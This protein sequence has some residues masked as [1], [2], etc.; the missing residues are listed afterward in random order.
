[1]QPSFWKKRLKRKKSVDNNEKYMKQGIDSKALVTTL[2]MKLP[3]LLVIAVTGAIVGSGLNLILALYEKS[4]AKYVS[5]T[6]YYIEFSP[7]VL[8]AADYYNDYTWNDVIGTDL[9]LGRIMEIIGNGYDRS[10]VKGMIEADIVSDVR[11]LKITIKGDNTDAVS[12]VQSAFEKALAEFGDTMNEFTSIYIID[13]SGIS[14]EQVSYFTFRAALLG[15][16]IFLF[17]SLFVIIFVFCLGSSFYTKRDISKTLDI[18]VLGTSFKDGEYKGVIHMPTLKYND[19]FYCDENDKNKLIVII[20]FGKSYR[21]KIT[22]E[23]YDMELKGMKVTG[24]I[25]TD[26]DNSWYRIYRG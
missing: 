18:P 21:E 17:I 3:I 22:D 9:I 12:T 25:M 23:I 19:M 16:F 6:K 24:A 2:I 26:V 1:L 13:D 15:A 8:D 14:K 5:E 7:G 11:Y 10:D 4:N 20:P